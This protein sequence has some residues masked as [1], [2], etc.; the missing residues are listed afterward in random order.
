MDASGLIKEGGTVIGRGE[1]G[2][3]VEAEKLA[4]ADAVRQIRMMEYRGERCLAP[5]RMRG[6]GNPSNPK[7]ELN[8]IYQETR[9]ENPPPYR[10]S[11]LADGYF[12][13][14]IEIEGRTFQG[15]GL[16]KSSATR[17]AALKVL[18]HLRGSPPIG[19]QRMNERKNE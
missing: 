2:R 10:V 3:R 9:R 16:S 18:E 6:G 1:A 19:Y 7:T 11:P 5:K 8:A 14:T 17:D 4:C 15:R 12:S 13:A